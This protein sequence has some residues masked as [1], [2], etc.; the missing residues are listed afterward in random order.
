M[1]V[2]PEMVPSH[3]EACIRACIG[4]GGRP[5]ASP[6]VRVADM[7]SV[8]GLEHVVAVC[9][10]MITRTPYASTNNESCPAARVLR[11]LGLSL[12]KHERV[13]TPR[14]TMM[15]DWTRPDGT[16][17]ETLPLGKEPS[18][19][20]TEHQ[21]ILP[22][23]D[24][25]RLV[26]TITVTASDETVGEGF[27]GFLGFNIEDIGPRDTLDHIVRGIDDGVVD[28]SVAASKG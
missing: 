13:A 23:S 17:V 14:R 24:E 11:E 4:T 16:V 21:K 15:V 26:L 20:R 6:A 9:D 27:S 25:M 7:V 8:F 18:F 1:T 3:V 19:R 22:T 10:A 5:G 28:V 12:Y 2:T